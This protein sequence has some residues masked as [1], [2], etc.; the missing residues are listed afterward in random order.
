M[1]KSLHD[2]YVSWIT[3]KSLKLLRFYMSLTFCEWNFQE[4]FLWDEILMFY[5]LAGF[6]SIWKVLN[7]VQ[8]V[9]TCKILLPSFCLM[10]FGCIYSP[11]HEFEMQQTFYFQFPFK[12]K[13]LEKATFNFT[14]ASTNLYPFT[15]LLSIYIQFHRW[16]KKMMND[17]SIISVF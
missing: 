15:T 16:S 11:I 4:H 17:Y 10:S 1:R 8:K 2:A 5:F 3:N 7:V 14:I 9:P 13:L 6:T 12:F